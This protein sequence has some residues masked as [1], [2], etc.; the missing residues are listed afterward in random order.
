M[1]SRTAKHSQLMTLRPFLGC[2]RSGVYISVYQES[3]RCGGEGMEMKDGWE[4]GIRFYET[5][6]V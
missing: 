3:E 6:R 2:V 4:S 1:T 5:A